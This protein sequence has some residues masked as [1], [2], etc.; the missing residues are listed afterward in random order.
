MVQN[1]LFFIKGVVTNSSK[2]FL[3]SYIL[4]VIVIAIY[5][6]M[7]ELI[8]FFGENSKW[9]CTI[10]LFTVVIVAVLK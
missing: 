2:P 4:S 3:T 8:S 7:P 5:V 10:K 9:A 1:I 6:V